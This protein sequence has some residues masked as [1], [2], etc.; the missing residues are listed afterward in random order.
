MRQQQ[1]QGFLLATIGV[2][3]HSTKAVLVKLG[4][5]LE[6][7]AVSLMFLRMIFA[8]PIYVVITILQE[9]RNRKT[10]KRLTGRQL[11]A[12]IFLGSLGYYVASLFDFLGLEYVSASVERLILFTYPT[13]V[14]IIAAVV[15]RQPIQRYQII[16]IA[17]TYL[18]MFIMFSADL[19]GGGM[20]FQ[21]KGVLLIICSALTYAG[22]L[23]G[24]Q[25]LLGQISTSRFTGY[26]MIVASICVI[27]HYLVSSDIP[28]SEIPTDAFG[29]GFLMA[30]FATVIPSYL[31]SKAIKLI[32]ASD[33]GIIG[34]LGPVSTIILAIIFLGE[35]LTLTQMVGALVIFGAIMW[36]N[37]LKSKATRS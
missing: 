5:R 4:Y 28:I 16:A 34:A 27:T 36:M 12:I 13:F 18:G 9:W 23:V 25:I 10:Q 11:G 31:I 21:W 33:M 3:L 19:M 1:L 22:Y 2:L 37:I 14:I 35:T 26:A 20:S 15:F 24:S 6:V 17:M 30:T 7:D 32:G 8:L 29:I